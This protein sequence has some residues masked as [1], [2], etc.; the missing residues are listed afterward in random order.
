MEYQA[1][2]PAMVRQVRHD[3][4][5]RTGAVQ[6][7]ARSNDCGAAT[8]ALNNRIGSC[9]V[10]HRQKVGKS[11]APGLRYGN[12]CPW[13]VRAKKKMVKKAFE[14]RRS[15]DAQMQETGHVRRG[16][17]SWDKIPASSVSTLNTLRF[18]ISE[19]HRSVRHPGPHQV[20]SDPDGQ[21]GSAGDDEFLDALRV[22]NGSSEGVGPSLDLQ[23]LGGGLVLDHTD[24]PP[25]KRGEGAEDRVS[26]FQLRREGLEPWLLPAESRAVLVTDTTS[27]RCH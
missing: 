5:I 3:H 15:T 12:P 26:L 10:W 2:T 13:A 21:V 18:L 6:V 14:P 23:G 11:E 4:S 19:S 17:R 25:Q 22:G 9:G 27:N 1:R 16:P 8:I 20:H 7:P 24:S